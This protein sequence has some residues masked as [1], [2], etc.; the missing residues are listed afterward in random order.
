[1][2]VARTREP[3]WFARRWAH[4]NLRKLVERLLAPVIDHGHT[5]SEL[6]DA[7]VIAYLH[8]FI[9]QLQPLPFQF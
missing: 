2:P 7:D 4:E 6:A 1:M 5:V 8:H 9:Q 3:E